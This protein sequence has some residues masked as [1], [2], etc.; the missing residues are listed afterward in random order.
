MA[1][2]QRAFGGTSV[3]LSAVAERRIAGYGNYGIYGYG[4][5]D[6]GNPLS[7]G[8]ELPN[9]WLIGGFLLVY[10]LLV[11]P[12]NYL[13]LRARKQ[14]ELSWATIPA[15]IAVFVVG[16][17]ILGVV[18][19]GTDTRLIQSS[20]IR[21]YD[22]APQATVDSFIG[23]LSPDRRTYDLTFAG[24]L[25]LTELDPSAQGL[26]HGNPAVIL[27]GRPTTIRKLPLDTW[28]L[29]GFVAEGALTYANPFSATLRLENGQIAGEVLNRSA[30]PL[31]DVGLIY[32][33]AAIRLGDLAPGQHTTVNLTPSTG[34]PVA[35]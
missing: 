10:V 20:V 35:P 21:V 3:E 6:P 24:D 5:S 26:A 1:L 25:P 11:G 27:Q 2:W 22:N 31:H 18:T 33:G 23:I 7:A 12:L 34:T 30:D 15:L 28:A 29:R 4:Y 8:V 32:G 14:L 13:I 16:A 17:Y 9:P 19:R